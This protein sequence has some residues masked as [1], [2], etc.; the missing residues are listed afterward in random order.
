MGEP[1]PCL[2]LQEQL[3]LLSQH[4]TGLVEELPLW[5]GCWRDQGLKH[6]VG[7]VH[8]GLAFRLR[9][10][11]R[12]AGLVMVVIRPDPDVQQCGVCI[13]GED[14]NQ[15][16]SGTAVP[17][18]RAPAAADRGLTSVASTASGFLTTS[19]TPTWK[20]RCANSAFQSGSSGASQLLWAPSSRVLRNAR[21]CLGPQHHVVLWSWP[22]SSCWGG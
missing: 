12:R 1:S 11:S 15:P 18:P 17:L 19:T 9:R 16:A 8:Q 21:S 14:T 22:S 3:Q 10:L 4:G 20:E 5:L 7:P 6:P 13:C 2:R